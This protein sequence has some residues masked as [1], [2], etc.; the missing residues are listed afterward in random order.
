V[1]TAPPQSV[2]FARVQAHTVRLRDTFVEARFGLEARQRFRAAASPPLRELFISSE[3]PKGG[4]VDFGLF[5]EATVLADRLFGK[6]DLALA[7]EI[8]R[9]ASGHAA[10][11][12]KRLIMRHI[13]PAT[14]LGLTAGIWSQHHDGGR[15][16]SRVLGSSG[17]HVSIV[18]FPTPHRAHCLSIGGWMQGSLEMGPR[19]AG[20]V[21]E[22]GCRA[23][24]AP[25][26]DF[27]LTWEE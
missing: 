15:L 21:R 7:W 22:L 3:N 10:G 1:S 26:C 16:V 17:L 25:A 12:W 24:G 6:G 9:F 18:D 14:V 23:L 4:W 13:R 19:R 11:L 2:R 5:V 8:G 20:Q 27:Q